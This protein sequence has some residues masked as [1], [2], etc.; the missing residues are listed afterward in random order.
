M[1]LKFILTLILIIFIIGCKPKEVA[2]DDPTGDIQKIQRVLSSQCNALMNKNL[3]AYLNTID[4]SDAQY[5]ND[6]KKT[7]S[8]LLSVGEFTKFQVKIA[9]V[10]FNEDYSQAEVFALIDFIFK[11]DVIGTIKKSKEKEQL[12]FKKISGQWKESEKE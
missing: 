11:S 8:E 7:T 9:N 6:A 10:N 5:Y 4:N 12:F 1:K 3:N 2:L